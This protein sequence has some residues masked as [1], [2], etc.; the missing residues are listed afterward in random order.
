MSVFILVVDLK[1]QQSFSINKSYLK[2]FVFQIILLMRFLFRK[3]LMN[4]KCVK[5]FFGT[6]QYAHDLNKIIIKFIIRHWF[7]LFF[8]CS[9]SEML[10]TGNND[11]DDNCSRWNHSDVSDI[12]INNE[13]KTVLSEI[14]LIKWIIVFFFFTNTHTHTFISDVRNCEKPFKFYLMKKKINFGS[15]FHLRINFKFSQ[16]FRSMNLCIKLERFEKSTTITTTKHRQQNKTNQI[17]IYW[18]VYLKDFILL[19]WFLQ[20]K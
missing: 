20:S 2:I 9:N 16:C 17:N 7:F 14:K 1:K 12:F 5:I 8:W 4:S 15:K 18:I 3:K 19:L 6:L 10:M 13:Y 11:D